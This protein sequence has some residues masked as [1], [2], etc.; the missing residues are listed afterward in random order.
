MGIIKGFGATGEKMLQRTTRHMVPYKRHHFDLSVTIME[1]GQQSTTCFTKCSFLIEHFSY[2]RP[3]ALRHL[4]YQFY[5][6]KPKNHKYND[7]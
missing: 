7:F 3:K 5:Q 1:H 2:L 4:N 6:H